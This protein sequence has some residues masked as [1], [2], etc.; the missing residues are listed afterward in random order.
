MV[1]DKIVIGKA[2]LNE[3]P[4]KEFIEQMVARGYNVETDG[5]NAI[6][7]G[8]NLEPF[9]DEIKLFV[10][11]VTPLYEAQINELRERAVNQ[12]NKI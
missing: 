11:D 12:L 1:V 3:K 7:T 4:I 10:A 5:I 2:V 6:I 9:F 8:D